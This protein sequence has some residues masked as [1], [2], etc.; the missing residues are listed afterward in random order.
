MIRNSPDA[1]FPEYAPDNFPRSYV[2]SD[3]VDIQ[4]FP[5]A[6]AEYTGPVDR[7]IENQ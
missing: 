2:V 3:I 4:V 5:N 7:T 1:S 6:F